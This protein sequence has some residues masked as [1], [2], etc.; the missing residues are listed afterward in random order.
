LTHLI[1]PHEQQPPRAEHQ[2]GAIQA[3][4]VQQQRLTAAAERGVAAG[5]LAVVARER[6]R[7]AARVQRRA[8]RAKPR[9]IGAQAGEGALEQ[10]GGVADPY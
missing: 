9:A 3:D 10:R 6:R 4:S 1:G 5:E 8:R 7:S 2:H